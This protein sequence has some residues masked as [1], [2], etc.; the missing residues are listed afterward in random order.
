MIVWLQFALCAGVIFFAGARLSYYG[1]V[2]AEKTGLGRTWIGVVLLASVTS[3][4]ELITEISSVAL[5][6][7]PDIAAGDVLGSCMF[8]IVIIALL[9]L[10]G[11]VSPIS[12]ELTRATFVAPM[13]EVPEVR[14]A[15]Q[16]SHP[17]II[18]GGAVDRRHLRSHWPEVARK[19]ASMMYRIEQEAE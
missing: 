5:V 10:M 4:P 1:D 3:L 11:G 17:R 9:D 12:R 13:R 6:G 8:N 15:R 14:S 18:G 16:V 7:V 19:L 2:L